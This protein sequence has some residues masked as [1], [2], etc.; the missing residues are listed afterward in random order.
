MEINGLPAHPLIVHLAV[1]LI[2]LAA[3][4]AVVYASV[5]R[6]RWATRWP[7]AGASVAAMGAA[8]LAYFSG[9]N[10]LEQRP[11]LESV[12][13]PHEERAEILFWLTIVFVLVVVLSALALGGPSPLRSGRGAR[14]KHAPLIEWTMV[15]MLIVFSIA[16]VAMTFQTGDKGARLVWGG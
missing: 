10:F 15:S 16:L 2:P 12:I 3:M 5:P 14:G 9:R 8:I 13:Q 11:E 4:L 6:W 7:M 1:V